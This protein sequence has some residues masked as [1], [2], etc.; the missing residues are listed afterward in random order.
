L[1]TYV[2]IAA[3]MEISSKKICAPGSLLAWGF[4]GAV[5]ISFL[6]GC[7]YPLEPSFQPSAALRA[8]TAFFGSFKG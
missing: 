8:E 6:Y 5:E 3:E 2:D 4:G 7:S 1:P